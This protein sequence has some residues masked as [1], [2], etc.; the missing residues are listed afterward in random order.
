MLWM[1]VHDTM[2]T[3]VCSDTDGSGSAI[4]PFHGA[5]GTDDTYE[6][7]RSLSCANNRNGYVDTAGDNCMIR[8]T[9]I[10]DTEGDLL[11]AICTEVS[12]PSDAK[13]CVRVIRLNVFDDCKV[14]AHYYRPLYCRTV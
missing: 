10:C 1:A 7:S 12:I 6:A 4:N 9:R 5:C 3:E 14:R 13:P 8:T 2:V 11:D